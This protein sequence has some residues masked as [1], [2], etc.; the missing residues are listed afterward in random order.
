MKALVHEREKV[1]FTTA[2]KI[3]LAVFCTAFLVLAM[4]A[5]GISADELNPYSSENFEN[6]SVGL[7]DAI[8]RDHPV[9]VTNTIYSPT[10]QNTDSDRTAEVADAVD[11]VRPADTSGTRD[12]PYL[13]DPMIQPDELV[14]RVERVNEAEL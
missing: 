2:K 5:Q 1:M 4:S 11:S 9:T 14:D 3:S 10:I 6:D 13:L 7:I 12:I 8:N